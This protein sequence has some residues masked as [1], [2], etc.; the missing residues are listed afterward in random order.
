M[1]SSPNK[2]RLIDGEGIACDRWEAPSI[3]KPTAKELAEQQAQKK[4][5]EHQRMLTAEAI[6]KLQQQAYE[7][8]RAEGLQKGLDEAVEETRQ[9]VG[10]L[11]AILNKLEQPLQD[12]DERLVEQMVNL[13]VT[14]AR[15]LVRREL[16]IDPGQVVA[17]VRETISNLPVGARNIRVFL[18]PEDA[19]VVRGVLAV[20]SA[21]QRWEIVEEPV[22]SRGGCKVITDSSRIDASMETRLTSIAASLLGGERKEDD[23]SGTD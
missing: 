7:E 8:G 23:E 4:V 17:V 5:V 13:S 3:Q 11:E 16:R 9:R 14:I 22:M 18:N 20:G 2:P 19:E 10:H 15:Q 1:S 12:L 6:E 21:E